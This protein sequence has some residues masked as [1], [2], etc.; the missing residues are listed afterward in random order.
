[1]SLSGGSCLFLILAAQVL[2]RSACELV[3]RVWTP[4]TWMKCCSCLLALGDNDRN[5]SSIF[6]L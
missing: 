3:V 6:I 1:M 2:F 4:G 5:A